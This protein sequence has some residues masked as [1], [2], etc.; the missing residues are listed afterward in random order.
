MHFVIA[1]LIVA[2]SAVPAMAASCAYQ[3]GAGNRIAFIKDG[4]VRYT[5]K[6]EAAETCRWS[7]RGKEDVKAVIACPGGFEQTFFF[8]ASR[9]G[10]TDKG[11]LVLIESR[12]VFYRVCE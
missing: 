1:A 6:G 11:L 7:L 10:R 4:K 9:L 8:S 2:S 12:D 3:D 5:P